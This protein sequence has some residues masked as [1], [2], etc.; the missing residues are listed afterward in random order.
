MDDLK[1]K[2]YHESC[3]DSLVLLESGL[4]EGQNKKTN[5]PFFVRFRIGLEIILNEIK[6]TIVLDEH[7]PGLIEKLQD[8]FKSFEERN[9]ISNNLIGIEEEVEIERINRYF[10]TTIENVSDRISQNK[11]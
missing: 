6:R 4:K 5:W 3:I 11:Q 2:P 8:F 9:V 7:V 1:L 10:E